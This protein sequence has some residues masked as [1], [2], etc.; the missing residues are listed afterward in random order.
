MAEVRIAILLHSHMPYVRRNGDWPV[1][2]EWILEAWAESYLPIWELIEDLAAGDTPGKLALTLTPVLAEQLGDAY[3]QERLRGYLENKVRQAREEVSRL[4]GM[5]DGPRARL[6]ALFGEDYRRLLR[7]YEE[8]F[9]GRMTEVLREGMEKGVLEVLASAAT[10]AHLPSLASDTSRRAQVEIGLESHRRRF[11]RDPVG[12]WL[13]E[14]SYAPHLDPLLAEHSPP[15]RYVVLDHTAPESAPENAPTWQPRRLGSTPLLALMRDRLAHDLVWTMH[16]YPSHGLYREYSKRDHDGHGYQ[17]WRVTSGATPL[18]HKDVYDPEAAAGRA[19]EDARDF[20]ARLRRRKEEITAASRGGG[21]PGLILAA[22]DTEL[23]GHWWREGSTWLREVLALLGEDAVLPSRVVEESLAG[24]PA[25]LSPR[26][27]AWN[28]D[29]TFSAWVNPATSE[30]WEE[31][32]RA[33]EDLP[34]QVEKWEG[35]FPESGRALAQA[36]REL[37]L[38]E[39]SDWT[40]MITRDEASDYARDRFRSHL[41]RYATIA[42]MLDRGS[43]DPSTLASLEDTDNIFPWLTPSHWR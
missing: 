3:L 39:A 7:G 10:H 32:R 35:R 11:G 26:M 8:R 41:G 33:E 4:Q 5:G 34:R 36:A 20:A 23:L 13:P 27:T 40:Y 43:I 1:G 2:E 6:A 37:L 42:E 28:V 29:G 15:L 24:E 14:C 25:T 22:Y 21:E 31:L 30:I 19:R 18:D 12:F 38:M 16:G 9:R 17:Y